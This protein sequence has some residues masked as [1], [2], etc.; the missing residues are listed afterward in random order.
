M[1]TIKVS[2]ATNIQLDWLVCAAGNKP[3]SNLGVWLDGR[4]LY[5]MFNY[6]T[7]PALMHPI[8]EREDLATHPR[9]IV[10]LSE[11][12]TE[13]CMKDGWESWS[14]P[15]YYWQSP[16]N[17]QRGITSLIAAARCYIVSKLGE[18]VEVPEGLT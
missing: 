2:E 9:F 7:N 1:K 4:N 10:G 6:T 5:N 16:R 3:P 18:T 15:R 13:V 11:R 12:G 17:V 8:I 14:Q